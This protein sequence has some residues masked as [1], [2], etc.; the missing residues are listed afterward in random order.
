MV[1]IKQI[2]ENPQL[3]K[4]G[5]R[6]KKFDVNID[7][8]LAID[9]TLLN[10]KKKLQ[11]L[12]TEKNRLGKE[13]P[14]LAETEKQKALKILGELK[15]LE[16]ELNDKI[17]EL[18][19]QFDA[20]MLEVPQPPS[21]EVPFGEDDTQNVELRRWGAIRQFDFEYKD[22]IQLGTA[23]NLIDVERGVKLAGTRNYFLKGDG[24]LLHRAVLQFALDFMI[25]KGYTPMVVP[26]LMRDE[27]M[28]GTGYYPGAEEQTYRMERDELNLVGTAEVPLTAYHSG[29]LLTEEMLP[30]KF[31][32][33]SSCFRREAGA[34]GK[35]TYGLYRIH[36]FD[37]V[38]Q[39]II[40]END[41]A[42]SIAYHQEILANSEAVMQAL[43][44]PYRV[45]NVCTGDLGRGQVQKFDVETWMPSRKGF[46]ETHSASRFYE[47]QARRMNLR[48]KTAGRQNLFCH[49]LNNTVIASPRVLIPILELYQNA[50]GSVTIPQALRPYMNN[51][52]KIEAQ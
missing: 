48:Y 16:A 46:G 31:V 47:F 37:K 26:L 52:E 14:R 11:D 41:E 44:L 8:L 32:A 23:L 39:V 51:R 27:A 42:K 12:T 20:L 3:F 5:A 6:A 2:R 7:D 9:S 22:H 45:V 36:Q 33:M 29:E 34:A 43:N 10:V 38:E 15:T 25:Q 35:D 24:A 40:G 50:D 4:D 13:I 49:T 1:D 19:P 21:P 17:K 30:A 28:R 18:Q